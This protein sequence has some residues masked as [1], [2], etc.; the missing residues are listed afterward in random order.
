MKAEIIKFLEDYI[1]GRPA[2]LGLSGG[3]DSAVV[4]HLLSEAIPKDQIYLYHLP[5]STNSLTDLQDCKQLARTLGVHFETL[6]I[7]G[8]L[9][10]Y[11]AVSPELSQLAIGNLKAR[12]RMTVLY[13][14]ANQLNGL[15]IGTGNKTE[16][17]LGYFTKYGDGG[18]DLLPIAHLYKTQVWE[19]ARE[20][21]VADHLI[22]KAPSAGLWEGQT[23]EAEIGV[24][25]KL[26]DQILQALEHN[27]ALEQ[28]DLAAVQR[29]QSLQKAGQH[30]QALPPHL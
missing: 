19:L 30:K 9:S 22:T 13:S 5:S 18:V 27:Q 23:D 28:F 24:P 16:L 2:I 11:L 15:V 17:Q 26:A 10:S 29:I 8:L 14:R 6:P 12:I 7:D 21:G 25:Y 20:L 4:A 3:I 1:Q